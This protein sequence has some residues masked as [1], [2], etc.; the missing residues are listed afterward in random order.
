MPVAP[1]VSPYR[2]ESPIRQGMVD[3]LPLA[4]ATIPWGI[5]CGSLAVDVGLT[6]IQAQLMSLLVFAGAAQL[7]SL[8]LFAA[9]ASTGSLLGTT[10]V[11][12][13]RHLLY[14]A[15][16]RNEVRSLNLRWRLALAFV[17]TDEMFAVVTNRLGR[18]ASFCPLHALSAGFA[19]YSVWNLATLAGIVLG[20]AAPDLDQFGFDFAIAA[21]FIAIVIPGIRSCP[22]LLCVITSGVSAVS[23]NHQGVEHGLIL[24]TGAGM[25][26]GLLASMNGPRRRASV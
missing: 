4:L 5:L 1:S 26:V 18:G 8:Q 23:L 2:E 21:T 22:T 15:V 7:A 6:A 10:A 3:I 14:A 19:M 12:S 9:G 16:F 20:H 17:L 25:I 11:I 13:A 24:S